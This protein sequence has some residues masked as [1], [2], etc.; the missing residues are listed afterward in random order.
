VKKSRRFLLPARVLITLLIIAAAG[1]YIWINVYN[2]CEVEAMQ[3]ASALLTSQLKRYDDLFQAT[4]GVYKN[5]VVLP[6]TMLQ[7]IVMDTNDVAVPACMQSA[8]NELINYMQTVIRAFHA[9]GAGEPDAAIRELINQSD[10]HYQNF[11]IELE[12]VNE[13]AP[14]CF[15]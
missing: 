1:T 14:F 11:T 3:D 13:C 5:S 15:P 6:L 8:K 4:T 12:T 7:Q 2:A 9:F 10:I